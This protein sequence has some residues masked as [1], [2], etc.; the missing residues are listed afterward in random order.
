VKHL[1]AV[2]LLTALPL[3]ATSLTQAERDTL[4]AQLSKSAAVFLNSLEGVSEA[5]WNYKPGPD[6]WSIAECAEH[7]AIADQMMFVFASQQLLKMTPP[8]KAQHRSDESVLDAALDRT[9]KVKT[10]ELLEPKGRYASKAAVLEAFE[11]GRARIVEYVKTTKNDLRAHGLESANGYT[12]ALPVPAQ[13]VCT[14]G[15]SLA[16][17]CGSKA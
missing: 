16:A 9:K 7:V 3:A 8:E 2:L 14:R 15:T 12:D 11:K 4:L 17:D 1:P 13:Y 6:R 10:A 5:Q